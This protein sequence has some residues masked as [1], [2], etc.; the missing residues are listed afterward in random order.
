[1]NDARRPEYLKV[2]ADFAAAANQRTLG[3]AVVERARW[4][5]ADCIPVIAAG[6]QTPEMQALVARHLGSSSA[7]V[8]RA[9]VLGTGRRAVATDASLLNGT[10]GTWLE[11]DEGNL[12]AKGHPGIQVVP[13]AVAA[14]QELGSSGADLIAAVALGY[15]ISSRIHRASNVN[16]AVHPHGT[17]GVIGAAIAVAKLKGF[18]AGQ[19]LELINVAA[20]MGMTTSRQTLLDGA[21]VRNIYTGHSGFMGSMAVRLVECGFT[22][23]VDSVAAIYGRILSS[24]F[25]PGRVIDKIGVEWLITQSYFKLHPT[26]R[27]VHSAIDALET[28]LA[29][30]RE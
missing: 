25:D 17:Y 18:D 5:I 21:T 1:M 23:E 29:S 22:G 2:L 9:W 26:G 15:E 24:T 10:A 8:G 3:P 14:A 6:M 30:G 13:A 20:T 16:L 11:L 4:I 27:Y 28:L 19:M 12:F 7:G